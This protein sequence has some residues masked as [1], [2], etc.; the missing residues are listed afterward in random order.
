MGY[1]KLL[2]QFSVLFALVA[3]FTGKYIGKMEYKN[4]LDKDKS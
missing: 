2:S 1:S 3:Y 4:K